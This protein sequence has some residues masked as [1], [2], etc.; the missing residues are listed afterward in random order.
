MKFWTF[1]KSFP[2]PSAFGNKNPR[3]AALANDVLS[4]E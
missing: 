4:Q 2:K 3:L 1:E